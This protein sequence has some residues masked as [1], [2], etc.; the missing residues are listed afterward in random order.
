MVGEVVFIRKPPEHTGDSTKLQ[1]KYRGPLVIME[2]LSN[3]IYKVAAVRTN[4][5][6]LY[7]KTIHVGQLKGFHLPEDKEEQV[8]EELSNE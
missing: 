1:S 7:A 2:V 4:E 5:G 6:R 3:Y 8:E